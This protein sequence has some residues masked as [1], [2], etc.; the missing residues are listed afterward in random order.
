MRWRAEARQLTDLDEYPDRLVG[1]RVAEPYAKW[2]ERLIN[3]QN[4]NSR[5]GRKISRQDVIEYGLRLV[6]VEIMKNGGVFRKNMGE[7]QD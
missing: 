3:N 1:T 2:L 7:N 4:E 5:R 6:Y